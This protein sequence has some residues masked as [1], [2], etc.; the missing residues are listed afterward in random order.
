M[1]PDSLKKEILIMGCGNPLFADDGFGYEVIK[2]LETIELPSNVEIIDAGTGGPYYL[3]SILDEESSVKKI[4]LVDII[5]FGLAPGTLKKLSI[6]DLPNIEKYNFDAHDMPLAPY[7]IEAHNRGIVVVIIGC[8]KKEVS[9]PD[10]KLGLSKEVNNA[11]NGAIEMIM[12][13]IHNK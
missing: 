4:I 7:L 2:K 10:I 5:D 13:E 8:Q 3:M 9:C 1:I 11:L 12:E 6:K